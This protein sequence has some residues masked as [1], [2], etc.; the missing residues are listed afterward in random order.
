MEKQRP[1]IGVN[2]FVIKDGKL[3]LGQ[4]K[5]T[6]G[7]GDW[8]LPGGHLEFGESLIFGA[9]REL[10]E[11]AGI[12]AKNLKFLNMVNDPN[13]DYHY[14]HL[15]FLADGFDGEV[16]VMEPDKCYEWKWFDVNAL[17]KNIFVGHQK[18]IKAFFDKV[19]FVD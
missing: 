4:R 15:S 13:L 19:S 9:N 16:K 10:Q 14:L 8:G 3:L 1:K 2:V 5:N 7:D 6:S 18:N 17:P 12:T 11:E